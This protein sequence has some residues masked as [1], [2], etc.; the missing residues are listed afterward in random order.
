MKNTPK[1]NNR[2]GGSNNGNGNTVN[3][4]S[5]PMKD[6]SSKMH[7]Q[8][9]YSGG[10]HGQ[11]KREQQQQ[12]PQPQQQTQQQKQ[13][14]Q[15]KEFEGDHPVVPTTQFG[16]HVPPFPFHDQGES[17]YGPPPGNGKWKPTQFPLLKN[18][19]EPKKI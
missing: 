4:D 10:G 5:T 13:Q 6:N 17:Y 19:T 16:S 12:Q 8:Q 1:Y 7:Q 11:S 3:Y 14:P 2:S 15:L 18:Q 9:Q